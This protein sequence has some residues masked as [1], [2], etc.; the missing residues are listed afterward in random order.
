MRKIISGEKERRKI[1]LYFDM[2]PMWKQKAYKF[3]LPSKSKEESEAKNSQKPYKEEKK[4]YIVQDD[5]SIDSSDGEINIC[6]M[7]NHEDNKITSHNS[8]HD[9]FQICKKLN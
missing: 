6:L 2:L 7:E 3:K 8:Y 1:I 5:N 4:A 9:L